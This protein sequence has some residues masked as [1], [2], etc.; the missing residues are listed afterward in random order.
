MSQE[1]LSTIAWQDDSRKTAAG[2]GDP[3]EAAELFDWLPKLSARQIRLERWLSRWTRGRRIP[4]GLEWLDSACGESIT[5]DAPDV[6]LRPSGLARPGMIA[7]LLVPRRSTRMAIGVENAVAHAVVDRMLG[8]DRPFAESRLQLT[9]V[10]WGIWTFVVLR[11]LQGLHDR[12]EASQGQAAGCEVPLG[13]DDVRL[14]RAGPDPFDPGGLGSVV[15]V[16]WGVRVGE[17]SGSVRLW[18]PE[19]LLEPMPETRGAIVR[20]GTPPSLEPAATRE[21]LVPRGELDT[22][23]RALAGTV[24]SPSG[25]GRM[26]KGVVLPLNQTRLTGTPASPEGLVDLVLD[27]SGTEGRYRISCRPVPD[28]GG[29]LIRVEGGPTREPAPRS[30]IL[31]PVK[32]PRTMSP[33]TAST[34]SGSAGPEVAPLDVPVTLSVELGRLNLTLARLTDLKPGDVLELG[35]HPRAPVELTSGGRVVAR[36]ELVQIDTELGVRV[37][38]VFL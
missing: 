19:S 27:L 29:R 21:P 28:S 13:P 10:E 9:P 11:A 30:P 20:S 25:L 36:G 2:G 18:I 6:L 14:D 32:E 34:G 15:T 12:D 8:F 35:R 26:S 3:G 7:H 33:S 4:L 16:R 1:T 5:V 22:E 23:W 17:I 37:T 24:T 38:S 31:L